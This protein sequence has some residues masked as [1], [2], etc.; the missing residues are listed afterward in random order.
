[1]KVCLYCEKPCSNFADD[2][3][4]PKGFG[5]FKDALTLRN[6]ICSKCNSGLSILEQQLLRHSPEAY[7]RWRLNIRSRRQHQDRESPFVRS[8]RNPEPLRFLAE[9]PLTGRPAYFA[10]R[11]SGDSRSHVLNQMYVTDHDGR[12]HHICLPEPLEHWQQVLSIFQQNR[13]RFPLKSLFY[14]TREDPHRAHWIVSNLIPGPINSAIWRGTDTEVL[15]KGTV[16]VEVGQMYFRAIAKIG[17]HHLLA[18]LP[19]VITGYER[20]FSRIK[21]YIRGDGQGK[22][23][24]KN[25]VDPWIPI[26]RKWRARRNGIIVPQKMDLSHLVHIVGYRPSNGIIESCV[27]L[28]YGL[29]H[30]TLTHVVTL[31]PSPVKTLATGELTLYAY[32]YPGPPLKDGSIGEAQQFQMTPNQHKMW[33]LSRIQ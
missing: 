14:S 21:D 7:V 26:P 20:E 9:D 30:V 23:I 2:H 8:D 22:D 6:K 25:Q 24:M 17:F 33:T 28:F 32:T 16:E 13:V 27:T 12:R 10:F 1:M 18:R 19:S 3:V 15:I 29:E 11:E 31:G 4:L 5:G